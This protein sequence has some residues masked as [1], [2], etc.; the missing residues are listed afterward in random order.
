MI[1]DFTNEVICEFLSTGL[2]MLTKLRLL[3]WDARNKL[4]DIFD[5]LFSY[6]NSYTAAFFQLV[7]D[8]SPLD[9]ASTPY[10]L[11]AML[12]QALVISDSSA[13][14]WT[15]ITGVMISIRQFFSQYHGEDEKSV[16]L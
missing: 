8:L 6:R 16:I 14:L 1:N 12:L 13:A 10:K 7:D 9:V 2:K 4:I 5:R 15:T 11:I 3:H